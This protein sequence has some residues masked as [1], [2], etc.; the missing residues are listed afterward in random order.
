MLKKLS[1]RAFGLIVAASMAVLPALVQPVAT[2]AAGAGTLFALGP[3]TIA[4][5]DPATGAV[6]TFAT[7]ALPS[8]FPGP[9][10][11]GLASDAAGHRLFVSETTFSPDFSTVTYQLVTVD[12]QT[13][14][15]STSPGM[16]QGITALV[17]DPA[18]GSVIGQANM[19]CPF[20]LVRIDPT[21][22]VQTHLADMPGVQPLGLVE[23]P[24]KHAIY[25]ATETFV[26]GQFQ[27]VITLVTVDTVT[28]AV[29]QSPPMN[30]GV[31]ALVYD[32][33]SGTLFGKTFCCQSSLVKI[34]PASGAE[35]V[36]AP[37]LTFGFGM[38]IDSA[39]HTVF[40][41]DD[42]IGPFGISQFIESINDQTGAITLS[43]NPLPADMFVGSM[44]FEGIAT[45]PDSIRADV[46]SAL[47]TG[48]ISN[49]GVANSLLAE[50]SQAQAARSR[51]Q[52]ATAGTMYHAFIN[53]VTAQS[54]KAIAA[55]TATQL[56][57]EAQLLIASCP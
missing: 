14:A 32:S 13:A 43:T 22:G 10:L 15:V 1:R 31:F 36:V 16:A 6:T 29:T 9:S 12:T 27:P 41:T 23:A 53:E 25:F 42:E 51:G 47:A 37:G 46:Q 8:G 44:A 38:T 4:K 33:V 21:T 50:L 26:L 2:A 54:G 40:T 5:V 39:T 7:L 30:T 17:Y 49:A 35:T 19:C 45:T 55:A 11:V 57:G 56:A 52:C 34:D 24:A 48:A 20:Q 18:S 28:G 3:T